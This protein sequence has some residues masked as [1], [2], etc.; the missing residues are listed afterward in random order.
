MPPIACP[1]AP[2]P[3]INLA[4]YMMQEHVGR[5][6]RVRARVVADSAVEAIRRLNRVALEPPIEIIIRGDDEQIQEFASHR[7][8][9]LG[10]R[11]SGVKSSSLEAY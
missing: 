9:E 6:S 10:G 4:E 7:H 5:A 11:A 2:L 1:Q 3:A 8:I